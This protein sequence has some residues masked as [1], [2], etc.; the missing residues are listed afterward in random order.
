MK[1]PEM[2]DYQIEHI[3]NPIM[4]KV[5]ENIRDLELNTRFNVLGLSTSA[6]KTFTICNF[7]VDSC[8][9]EGCDVIYTTPN[10]A[11]LDEVEAEI[12]AAYPKTKVVK[13]AGFSGETPFVDPGTDES[14]IYIAHPTFVSQNKDAIGQWSRDRKLVVFSDEAHKGFMCPDKDSTEDAH[15]YHIENFTAEWYSCREAIPNVGWFLV[16]ATPLKTTENPDLFETISTFFDNDILSLYQAASKSVNIYGTYSQRFR[17]PAAFDYPGGYLHPNALVKMVNSFKENCAWVSEAT[18][19]WNLPKSKPVM[20][21]QARNTQQAKDFFHKLDADIGIAISEL[22]LSKEKSENSYDYTQYKTSHDVMSQLRKK[23]TLPTVLIA[24]KSVGESVNIPGITNLVS[25]H[26]HDSV[27]KYDITHVVEQVLGRCIRFPDIE[28]ISTWTDLMEYKLKRLE[29]GVPAEILEKWIDLV[30]NY[31]VH[32]VGTPN[33]I[34]GAKNFFSKHTMNSEEWSSYIEKVQEQVSS[35][36]QTARK[37][38]GDTPAQKSAQKGSQSYKNYKDVQ[39]DCEYCPSIDSTVIQTL[40]ANYSHDKV[41]ICKFGVVYG[42]I[43]EEYY[44]ASMEV[45]HKDGNRHNNDDENL[46][47]VCRQQ[48]L[49]LDAGIRNEQKSLQV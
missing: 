18:A 14:V 11:S 8:L 24:N 39:R 23:H 21:I 47:T 32:L 48:H 35:K 30:F 4:N 41:P 16:S 7:V 17:Q 6:G 49:K 40:N 15:G 43:A 20:V 12:T 37:K 29:E 26:R 25:F 22:K 38:Y 19:K 13:I 46:I 27:K 36:K 44:Y 42:K 2:R 45:H 28:G 33:N 9:S 34:Q 5:K 31:D 1:P 10:H 3:Y